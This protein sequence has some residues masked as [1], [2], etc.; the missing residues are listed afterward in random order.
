[1]PKIS[2]ISGAYNISRC[3]SF[4]KSMES[5]L[6]QSFSDFEFIICD[7]GST[8]NTAELLEK[9]ERLDGRIKIIRNENN[10]GLAYSLNR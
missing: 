10:R 9:Y 5:I 4:E 1:M 3:Y 7:D 2:I 6:S 8:D